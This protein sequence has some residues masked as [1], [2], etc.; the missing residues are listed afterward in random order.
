MSV[1]DLFKQVIEID[2]QAEAVRFENR[3]Y[4]WGDLGRVAKGLA[5]RLDD[6]GVAPD[7]PVAWV[8]RNHPALVG[9]AIGIIGW[10]RMLAPLS[11]HQP[12]AKLAGELERM[13]MAVV[14]ALPQDWSEEL[15]A[16]ARK[17]GAL[18]LEL[19]IDDDDAVAL[20]PGLEE[21][22]PGPHREPVPGTPIERITSGTTGTPKRIQGTEA[23]FAEA[24]RMGARSENKSNEPAPLT[25]KRSPAIQFNPF[26]HSGGMYGMLLTIS[27][28]RKLV[29][30]ERFDVHEWADAVKQ[31]QAKAA[32]LV[33]TMVKM[34]LD[35]D[36]PDDALQ[37]IIAIR[38][39]TAPLDPDLKKAFEERFG[40]PILIEYGASEFLGGVAGW[41]LAD[42]RQF[43][44]SKR[45]AVG[46]PRPD[47]E[48]RVLDDQGNELPTGEVGALEIRCPRFGPDWIPTTDLASIDED[49]FL[50]IHGRADEAII[51]GGFKVL[52][53]KVA[54]ALRLHPG[55]RD[56]AVIAIKDDRLGQTPL[57][58]VEPMPGAQLTPEELKEFAREQLPPYDVPAAFEFMEQM[59]RTVSMKVARPALRELLAGKY[60]F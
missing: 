36:I 24:L 23:V 52:P 22:G 39:S 29:L 11:P 1:R 30:F 19:R 50:F 56:A 43:S 54:E 15:K 40:V 34:V 27:Q 5:G 21:I 44:E 58:I 14:V 53:E 10:G 28:G 48:L 6:A 18:G 17:I 46:R 33:P 31:Y 42:H 13:R 7:T 2:P 41:S 57:A 45:G 12:A 26:A 4:T 59:P 35:S 32:S 38:S 55:V 49:G 51:R 25:L 8:A 20:L 37:S 3:W 16:A 47:V 60:E 9:A